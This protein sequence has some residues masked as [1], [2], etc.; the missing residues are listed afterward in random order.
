MPGDVAVGLAGYPEAHPRIGAD[1]LEASLVTKLASA[2]TQ[3]LAVHIVTQFCFDARPI[4]R[5]IAWLR[6]RGIHVPVRVGLAGPTS[7]S[8]WMGYA[9]RCGVKASASALANR[10]GLMSHLFKAI[11]PDAIILELSERAAQ[12]DLT[13]ASAHMYSFG[14]IDATARWLH[15]VQAG[16]FAL[17]SE[18]GFH[19]NVS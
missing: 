16:R 12:G 7:M 5:W 1:E 2:Q 15:R 19:V 13:D 3:G 4:V 6:G 9:R 11:S 14:G 17:E 10:T 18:G 8:T